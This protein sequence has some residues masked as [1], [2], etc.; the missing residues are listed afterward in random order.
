MVMFLESKGNNIGMVTQMLDNIIAQESENDSEKFKFENL[1]NK[2]IKGFHCIG[3][4]GYI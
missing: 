1:S 3:V 4:K 2:T